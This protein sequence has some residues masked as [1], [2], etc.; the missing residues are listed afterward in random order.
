MKNAIARMSHANR[1]P[2]SVFPP[3]KR[4]ED[5]AATE[6]RRRCHKIG[7]G[8][9]GIRSEERE[10][11][12]D[13][14]SGAGRR[15]VLAQVCGQ[16]AEHL[17]AGGEIRQGGAGGGRRQDRAPPPTRPGVNTPGGGATDTTRGE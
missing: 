14:E 11:T 3:V 1:Y 12:Q 2:L 8:R 6:Y 7:N 13:V 16:E 17:A 4:D 9:Q 5:R 15:P 10:Q